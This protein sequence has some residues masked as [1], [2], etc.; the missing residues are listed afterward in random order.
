MSRIATETL[1]LVKEIAIVAFAILAATTIVN[2]CLITWLENDQKAKGRK[3]VSSLVKTVLILVPLSSI[4]RVIWF[5]IVDPEQMVG[6][7]LLSDVTLTALDALPGY[8]FF[9]CCSLLT[10]IW[11]VLGFSARRQGSDWISRGRTVVAI[12][13]V[14]VYLIWFI[15]VLLAKS[16][17]NDGDR[18]IYFFNEELVYGCTLIIFPIICYPLGW[19]IKLHLNTIPVD[20]SRMSKEIRSRQVAMIAIG[21]SVILLIIGII[22]VTN[23]VIMSYTSASMG[24]FFGTWMT[25]ITLEWISECIM[26]VTLSPYLIK[27]KEKQPLM[28]VDKS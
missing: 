19:R 17:D 11:V 13:N 12:I 7:D 3:P 16:T 22:T 23:T 9:T 28:A 2:A 14:T 24:I 18:F 6:P 21:L 25:E 8:L 4:V 5:V 26:V 1:I 10:L 27:R 20:S 15:L